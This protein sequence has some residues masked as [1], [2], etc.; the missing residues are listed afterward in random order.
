MATELKRLE[1][2]PLRSFRFQVTIGDGNK[3]RFANIG[4]MSVSGLNITTDVIPYREGGYN[5]S[6]HKLP[7]QSDF[8]PVT[9]SRG[10]C[11]GD[12]Q[13]MQWMNELFSYTQ[14]DSVGDPTND[15]RTTVQIDVMS[16]P[17]KGGK[18]VV[19]ASFKLHQA[20]PT[21]IAFSDL[22]AG[23]NTV[24][25]QQMTLVHE[26]FEFGIAGNL[27]TNDFKLN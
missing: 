9:F 6:P 22:D 10:L 12:N 21:A 25:I 1:T 27:V 11:V 3:N 2:D 8:Q 13:M 4:F 7:G 23:A 26:G 19:Q 20:W 15:F 18:G 24:I 17:N 16:H 5:S 14:A